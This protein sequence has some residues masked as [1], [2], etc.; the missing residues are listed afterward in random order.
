LNDSLQV[1]LRPSP[2]L[3]TTLGAGHL[4][5][6]AAA[7]IGLPAP[8]A[9]LVACGLGL[10]AAHHLGVATHRSSR[11]VAGLAFRSDGG[12]ALGDPAGSWLPA[13]LRHCAA[14]TGW[15]AVLSARDQAGRSRTAVILPDAIDPEAFRR[16]RVWLRWRAAPSTPGSRGAGDHAAS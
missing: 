6:L 12:L 15:L 8:A 13:E 10:S 3:A 16:L 4:A 11:A 2:V 14:P 5:A 9:A 7:V 1:E